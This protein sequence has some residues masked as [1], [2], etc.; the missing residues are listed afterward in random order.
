MQKFN[1]YLLNVLSFIGKLLQE[2]FKYLMIALRIQF[3][4]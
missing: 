4:F 3:V 1:T 2:I